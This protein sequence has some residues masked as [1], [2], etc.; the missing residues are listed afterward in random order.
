M[1]VTYSYSRFDL[2]RQR[3]LELQPKGLNL[4]DRSCSY[5]DGG[6]AVAA[7]ALKGLLSQRDVRGGAVEVFCQRTA[8]DHAFPLKR[9]YYNED[10]QPWETP[11]K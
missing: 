10:S 6:A 2:L 4:P 8:L 5:F 9:I 7:W 3:H 11:S 1:R